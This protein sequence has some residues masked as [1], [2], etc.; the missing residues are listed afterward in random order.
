MSIY[1]YIYIYIYILYIYT[2]VISISKKLFLHRRILKESIT[3]AKKTLSNTTAFHSN[4]TCEHQTV[5]LSGVI[6]FQK[7]IVFTHIFESN[8]HSW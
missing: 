7:I 2:H 6:I 5:H 8:M 4:R 1:I 3:V